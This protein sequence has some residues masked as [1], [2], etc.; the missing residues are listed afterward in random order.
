MGVAAGV[1]MGMGMPDLA[2]T[3]D[4]LVDADAKLLEELLLG[5]DEE[6]DI[7]EQYHEQDEED[8]EM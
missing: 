6:E 7:E 4:E 1:T 5:V 3:L 8:T 2:V